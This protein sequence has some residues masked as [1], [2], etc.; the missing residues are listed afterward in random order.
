MSF[1]LSWVGNKWFGT[2]HT[3]AAQWQSACRRPMASDW[4][5]N[6]VYPGLDEE[7]VGCQGW[8]G[9]LSA[10]NI[11]VRDW[12]L[13]YGQVTTRLNVVAIFTILRIDQSPQDPGMTAIAS[14]LQNQKSELRRAPE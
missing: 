1:N 10:R 14:A 11:G 12:Y 4:P 8:E 6:P 9:F 2:K 13:G 3:A 7:P 5:D